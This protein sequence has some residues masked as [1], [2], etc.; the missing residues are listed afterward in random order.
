MSRHQPQWV[1][2]S[3]SCTANEGSRGCDVASHFQLYFSD[4]SF[5]IFFFYPIDSCQM[6]HLPWQQLFGYV[7]KS[8]S[9]SVNPILFCFV[10]FSI[11]FFKKIIYFNCRIL[12]FW[13]GSVSVCDEYWL[14]V[15][16][17]F[18]SQ[19]LSC[20]CHL[21][22]YIYL[23]FEMWGYDFPSTLIKNF[24]AVLFGSAI[25]PTASFLWGF[26]ED[27]ETTSP[28]PPSSLSGLHLFF[29]KII[30]IYVY[31]KRRKLKRKEKREKAGERKK[32]S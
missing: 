14:V 28:L 21:F 16:G 22:Y 27:S 18:G 32:E 24:T 19:E 8:A 5:E 31:I 3:S 1:L 29:E 13:G 10:F 11:L 6:K 15:S 26:W 25:I 12:I 4:W 30:N 2:P 9:P 7:Y 17:F 23:C 20:C